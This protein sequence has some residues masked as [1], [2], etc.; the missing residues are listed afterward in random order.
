MENK[1]FKVYMH[2]SP[3]GKRYIGI[4]CQEDSKRRWGS[5]GCGYK[6]NEY[7]WKAIKKYG[8]DNFQHEILFEGL[9]E[10]ESKQKEIE[11]IAFYDTTN[12]SN[13]Y[14]ITPGGDYNINVTPKPV[15]Q[16]TSNGV[17]IKEYECIKYASNETGISKSGIS[18]CCN[19]K[20][21]TA[22]NFIWTFS[23]VELTEEHIAWCNSDKRS[24]N[25]IVV[26]RYSMSG[27]VI[28]EYVSLTLAGLATNADP[29]SI[30]LCCKGEYKSVANSIWRYAWEELTQEH[31]EWCNTLSS[32]SLKKKVN[33][34]LRDGT[35]ICTYNSIVE[36]CLKTGVSRCG[37]GE[38]CRRESKTAGGF[39]WQYF[40]EEI[41]P[42]YIKW[43]NSIEPCKEKRIKTAVIQ[44]TLDGIFI[45]IYKSL[46][47]AERNTNVSRKSIA[48]VCKGDKV[49]AGN[50]IWRYASEIE[51]PHAPLFPTVS[52]TL[53]EIAR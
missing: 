41:T 11:L 26:H 34:Y 4:T 35:F 25:C 21:K 7:F 51:D 19:N 6:D 30:T 44:Y 9:T 43:C 1:S 17:F 32:D 42:E 49:Q 36:A 8:W 31:L 38:C 15:K 50:F 2:T 40:D 18:L 10:V 23:D 22:G 16:Y 12:K 13:G 52:P 48:S 53:L 29:T 28:Q 33:Q 20:L 24:E 39:L 5:N 47:E 46:T 3:N 37:I 27:E 45:A 14:N